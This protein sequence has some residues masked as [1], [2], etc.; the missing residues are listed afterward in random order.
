[1]SPLKEFNSSPL[2]VDHDNLAQGFLYY[3]V[4]TF[5]IVFFVTYCVHVTKK[6]PLAK[7]FWAKNVTKYFRLANKIKRQ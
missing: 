7:L 5:R 4:N 6:F 3:P 1:M 2:R